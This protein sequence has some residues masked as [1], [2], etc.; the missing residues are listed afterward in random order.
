MCYGKYY[1]TST[2]SVRPNHDIQCLFDEQWE[3]IL[4]LSPRV[5]SEPIGTEYDEIRNKYIKW[6]IGSQMNS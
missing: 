6:N 3:P 1:Q 4:S 2:E 5:G